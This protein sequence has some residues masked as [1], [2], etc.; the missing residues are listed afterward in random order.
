V[1]ILQKSKPSIVLNGNSFD[2][3]SAYLEPNTRS[4]RQKKPCSS[5]AALICCHVGDAADAIPL[6]RLS[7]MALGDFDGWWWR[8]SVT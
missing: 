8:L 2:S 7:M 5:K 6:L 1:L 3:N 4:G